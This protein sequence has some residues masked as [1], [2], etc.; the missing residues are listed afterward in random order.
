MWY[1]WDLILYILW[2]SL[3]LVFLLLVCQRFTGA[4]V[5]LVP[6]ACGSL[7]E[8]TGEGRSERAMK[9]MGFDHGHCFSPIIRLVVVNKHLLYMVDNHYIILVDYHGLFLIINIGWQW[10]SYLGYHLVF[11]MSGPH[12]SDSSFK[13]HIQPIFHPICIS[14]DV[15]IQLGYNSFTKWD[16][17]PNTFLCH[18]S[19]LETPPIHRWNSH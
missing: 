14:G 2:I 19:W 17:P 15:P 10:D 13:I 6:G 18:Q 12:E 8:G 16:A 7:V 4:F 5:R 11:W 1:I 3:I 9:M